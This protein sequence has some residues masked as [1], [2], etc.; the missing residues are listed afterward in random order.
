MIPS[1]TTPVGFGI[2]FA[3]NSFCSCLWVIWSMFTSSLL[4]L[5][6]KN[7][8]RTL[9]LILLLYFIFSERCTK[10][11]D[12]V[13]LQTHTSIQEFCD[14]DHYIE[15]HWKTGRCPTVVIKDVWLL[16]WLFNAKNWLR[17]VF[18]TSL[19]WGKVGSNDFFLVTDLLKNEIHPERPRIS[20][21]LFRESLPLSRLQQCVRQSFSTYVIGVG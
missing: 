18:R 11:K 1:E 7:S 17:Q 16:S 12:V 13:V 20:L 4:S 21:M 19:S 5:H 14:N 2:L 9:T 8:L 6:L 10:E 15:T 3:G